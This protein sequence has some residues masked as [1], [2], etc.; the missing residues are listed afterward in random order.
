M[1]PYRSP[2]QDNNAPMNGQPPQQQALSRSP[3]SQQ[4]LHTHPNTP[5]Q[6]AQPLPCYGPHPD[7]LTIRPPFPPIPDTRLI[8]L[9]S[10]QPPQPSLPSQDQ[11][12]LPH[13]SNSGRHARAIYERGHYDGI[14]KGYAMGLQAAL[15]LIPGVFPS[16]QPMSAS[17]SAVFAAPIVHHFGATLAAGDL[18]GCVTNDQNQS[19][20]ESKTAEST[21]LKQRKASTSYDEVKRRNGSQLVSAS[22]HQQRDGSAASHNVIAKASS[23]GNKK[24]QGFS[25]E[26]L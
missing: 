9:S 14:G 7:S 3:W 24:E 13:T 8:D 26:G 22:E 4:S 10:R 12:S 11:A 15:R 1:I 16:S 17:T 19:R 2:P 6:G 25:S 23:E 21:A 5:W 20:L 18:S